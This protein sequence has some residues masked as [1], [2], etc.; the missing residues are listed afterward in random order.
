[1]AKKTIKV[2]DDIT[3]LRH[4]K[5][6]L[7]AASKLYEDLTEDI[8]YVYPT[9]TLFA[10][11]I[12]ILLKFF[13]SEVNEEYT[14]IKVS[15]DDYVYHMTDRNFSVIRSHNLDGLFEQLQK[16]DNEISNI[17]I[18]DYGYEVGR[19]LNEDLQKCSRLFEKS[20]YAYENFK[21][22]LDTIYQINTVKDIASVLY[23]SAE[24]YL[25]KKYG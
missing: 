17:F 8:N 14:E 10:F 22:P 24:K 4:G 18:K 5:Q 15:D 19:Q 6:Y 9:L 1:M 21:P 3:V 12:E 23:T 13:L 16:K 25:I 20:R 7:N 2:T 11:S